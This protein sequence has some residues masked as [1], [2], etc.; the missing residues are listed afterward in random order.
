MIGV[1]VTLNV[2]D[3]EQEA[4][5]A[6]A[7]DLIAQVKANEGGTLVYDLV[8]KKDSD[9]EYCFMEQYR[10]QAALDHHGK[11]DY[12]AAA[13]PKLGACLAGTPTMTFYNS[14]E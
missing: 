12:F 11:T 7:K 1:V 2:K 14:V 6:A 8:K 5:E 10:D 3:G 13:M 4:F 9:T